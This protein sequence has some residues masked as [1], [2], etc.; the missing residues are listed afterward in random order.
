MKAKEFLHGSLWKRRCGGLE[1]SMA[2]TGWK[3]KS[4]TADCSC[5]CGSWKQHWLNFSGQPWPKKCSIVGCENP[6]EVG[7]HLWNPTYGGVLP[8]VIVPL[9]KDCNNPENKDDMAIRIGIKKVSAYPEDT[10]GR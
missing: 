2:D 8:E 3:N 1:V 9:C 5:K 6:A 10:C 7:A 4:G